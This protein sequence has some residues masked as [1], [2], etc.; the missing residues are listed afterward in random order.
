LNLNN[1]IDSESHI[2]ASSKYDFQIELI[3]KTGNNDTEKII[4]ISKELVDIFGPHALLTEKNIHKY[5]NSKTLPFIARNKK[6]IIG[7]IIGV[8]LEY[9]KDESWAHFDVNLF[10]NNTL[11]TYAFVLEKKFQIK[12][13]YAKTLKKIYLS[14]AKKR[15]YN[16]ITGHVRSDIAIKFSNTEIVKTFP[17]WYD[18]KHS[19]SY[20]RRTI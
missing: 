9:F 16:Y 15:N 6:E 12:N 14:W 18:A 19:F 13:G 11:Y 10:K 20:Y 17:I 4:E 3:K 8:P 1:H 2:I 5:F 7:Y